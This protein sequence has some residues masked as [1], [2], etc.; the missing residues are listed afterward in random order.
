MKDP[1]KEKAAQEKQAEAQLRDK[2]TLRRKQVSSL[3][4]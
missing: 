4:S 2:E 1:A 3:C